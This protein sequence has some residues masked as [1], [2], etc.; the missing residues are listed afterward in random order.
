V[1]KR[2]KRGKLDSTRPWMTIIGVVRHVQSQ[3]LDTASGEQLYFPFYQDPS[4]YNMSLVV[5]TGLADALSL[6]SAVRAAIQSV[7]RN[8]PVYD[9]FTLRQV[10]GN[11]LA[12]RRF[13]ML[14]MGIFAAVA[15]TLAAVGI[16]GV[17]SYAVAQRTHEIGIRV[18]LGARAGHVLRL[19]VGQGLALTLSGVGIGLL[20][21]LALTRSLASL[22]FGI[23][24][25]DPLTFALVALLLTAVALL[26]CYV[27]ARRATRVDPM[28][29]LRHE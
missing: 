22:L 8:Q 7:D 16:Y 21:A 28:V 1:G 11:S 15:L 27:P 4:P 26:A 14:L 19:V 24:A 20:A 29:A 3:R 13:S 9:V 18:A 17:M 10:V 12:E 25:T 2:I 5:R 23:S 6:N